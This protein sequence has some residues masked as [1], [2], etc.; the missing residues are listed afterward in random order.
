[1]SMPLGVT[2]RLSYK[3][4]SCWKLCLSFRKRD[5]EMSDYPIIVRENEATPRPAKQRYFALILNWNVG[6]AGQSKTEALQALEKN[7]ARA[8]AERIISGGSIPRP[9]AQ[10]P[11]EFASQ[12]RIS[13][14][15]DL[16]EDFI[17]RILNVDGAWISDES[18]LW[19]FHHGE[20]NDALIARINELYGVDVSDIESGNL[21]EI[22][23]RV[24]TKR[25]PS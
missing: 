12:K 9:G 21:A 14:H 2:E 17:Q 22:L 3:V 11:V 7:F 16:A 5:W 15:S 1:M 8:K 24:A 19:D 18:S 25:K 10:V 6:G 20:T 23:E 13:A 4:R